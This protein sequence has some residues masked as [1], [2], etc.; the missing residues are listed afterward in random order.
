MKPTATLAKA[1]YTAVAITAQHHAIAGVRAMA[2]YVEV[3]QHFFQLGGAGLPVAAGLIGVACDAWMATTERRLPFITA[4]RPMPIGLT[5][6]NHA[7]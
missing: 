7:Q 1:S 3:L 5:W 6:H 2:G 4:S